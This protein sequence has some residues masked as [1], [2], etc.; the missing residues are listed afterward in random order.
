M[1]DL[2]DMTAT[3]LAQNIARGRISPVEA[4]QAAFDRIRARSAL[5]AFV[6]L[7]EDKA[8]A[9]ARAAEAAVRRGDALG[10]LHGVPFSVKDLIDTEGVRTTHGSKIFEHSVPAADA[11]SVARSRAAGGILIGKTTT[12]EFGHKPEGTSPVSGRTLHPTHPDRSPGASSTGSAVAVAAGMGPLSIGSDGGGSIRI[13]AACCGIVG[14]KATLGMIPHLQLPDMFGANS[15]V[16]PMARTVADTALFFE[17]M[18]GFD[19]RD[20]YG[21]AA[22]PAERRLDSLRGLR[23]GWMPTGGASVDPEVAA[24]A[25]AAVE[26]MAA[27]GAAVDQIDLD[28]A[29]METAFLT[30][31]RV[32]LSARV[33]PHVARFGNALDT[34]LLARILEGAALGAN[35]L[36]AANYERTRFF[37]LLQETLN[38]FDVIVSPVLTAPAIPIALDTS[39]IVEVAGNRGT[40]R[41]AWYPFTYPLNLTGHPA[42]SMPCGM[43]SEGLPVGLQIMGAWYSDRMILDVAGH[44]EAALNLSAA[45]VPSLHGRT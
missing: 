30:V 24:L 20:P 1:T 27:Q 7:N 41:G 45:G 28:F 43:T 25:R 36:A 14:F 12:P 18:A 23:V 15:Y 42:I 21:Q 19:R 37:R 29:A 11:V 4:V 9:A 34:T 35:D 38:R 22:L 8:L 17:A 6:T 32:G 2:A 44:L 40:I 39:G 33:G 26:T 13:P 5:N 31:L 10:P 16:G 3:A